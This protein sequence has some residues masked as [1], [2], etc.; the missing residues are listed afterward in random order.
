MRKLTVTLAVLAAALVVF[1][2]VAEEKK[3]GSARAKQ[4]EVKGTLVPQ[5]KVY[6]RLDKN[7]KELDRFS[8]GQSMKTVNC[9]KIACPS[10]FPAN[11]VCWECRDEPET[12]NTGTKSQ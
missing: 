2:V 10:T 9:A 5:G 7:K 3:A 1:N 6:V 12:T 11:Y 8:A 4:T